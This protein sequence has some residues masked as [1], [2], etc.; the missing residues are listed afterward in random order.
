MMNT[1]R[2]FSLSIASVGIRDVI[3]PWL[4]ATYN[5]INVF[6]ED[7]TNKV[8]DLFGSSGADLLKIMLTN[9]APVATNSVKAD[10]TEISAGNGYTA[11]GE[12]I[13]ND[14][15][16]ATATFTLTG[17]KVI[18]TCV[19]AA[20]A[21]FR[22]IALYNDTPTSPADPLISWWD[23]GSGVTLNVGETFTVKFNNGDP[24]GTVFT[25]A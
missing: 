23:H 18:W 14:G 4:F 20:M 16:R 11:G 24:T 6:V 1:L 25:L 12:D 9:V 7:L 8:H 5:K 15:T 21:T 10:L 3:P 13:Q 17:T 22:Y 19:T 2:L